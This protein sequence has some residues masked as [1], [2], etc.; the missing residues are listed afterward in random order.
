[1]NFKINLVKIIR[2]YSRIENFTLSL[3]CFIRKYFK[4]TKLANGAS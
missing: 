1:M 3:L 2:K 4:Q